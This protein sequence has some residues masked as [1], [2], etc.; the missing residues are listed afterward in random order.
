MKTTLQTLR[1]VTKAEGGAPGTRT[2][3]PLKPVARTMGSRLSCCSP[4]CGR[5]DQ[6]SK[7][8]PTEELMLGQVDMA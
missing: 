1:S 3:F 6:I 5:V 2:E 7:L 4:R 8:Q